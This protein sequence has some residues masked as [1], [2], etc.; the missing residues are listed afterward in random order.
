[1]KTEPRKSIETTAVRTLFVLG[2]LAVALIALTLVSL[3]LFIVSIVLI[4]TGKIRRAY[5]TASSPDSA[6]LEVLAIY[7]ALFVMMGF[8]G[9]AM[10]VTNLNW[11]WLALLI[12]P[13]AAYWAVH[14]G[15][16]LDACRKAVGWYSGSG[17]IREIAAG[18]GGY[19]AGLVVV[20]VGV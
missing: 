18:I 16:T 5:V 1:P 19:L 17:W 20:A 15:I 3:G 12:I 11:N 9:R 10:H 6:F 7:L 4:K 2:F 14:R 13:V 8:A